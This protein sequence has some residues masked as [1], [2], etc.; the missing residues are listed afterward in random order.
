MTDKEA[1]QA[2]GPMLAVD[3]RVVMLSGASRG[4]GKAI[5][6]RLAG[7]GFRLSLGVRDVDAAKETFAHIDDDRLLVSR[8][9]ARDASSAQAWLDRTL[10]RFGGVDGLVNNAGIWK[11]VNFDHGDE[12]DLDAMWE[13]NAKAPFRVT[14]LVLPELRKCGH[15]RVVNIASTDGVRFR[16]RSCSVGYT[17]SKHALMAVSQATRHFGYEDGVRATALCPGA[18]R[19]EMIAGLP[20]VTPVAE[21]LD[22]ATIAHLVS[23]VLCL[24]NNAS[25]AWLPVNTRLESSL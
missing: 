12:S 23:T 16:D 21:Q 9:D 10:A 18:I 24:P 8:F 20:G 2:Q 17:M 1:E 3:S 19:T 13:V 22:P 25:V 11:Q 5:A 15:G 4:L 6:D 7:D 14:R